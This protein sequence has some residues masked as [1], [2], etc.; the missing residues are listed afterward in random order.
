MITI[1][2]IPFSVTNMM[3]ATCEAGTAYISGV[4]VPVLHIQRNY[5]KKCY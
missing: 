4:N 3:G 2:H 1:K 5:N